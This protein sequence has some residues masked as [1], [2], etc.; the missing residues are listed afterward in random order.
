MTDAGSATG[1]EI[2]NYEVPVKLILDEYKTYAA[3]EADITET[4]ANA[5]LE[6][7]DEY[8]ADDDDARQHVRNRVTFDEEHVREAFEAEDVDGVRV[9]TVT[10]L[11]RATEGS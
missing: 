10:Q 2:T 5:I 6:N 9:E 1:L 11:G 8:D 3:L 4:A 7:V